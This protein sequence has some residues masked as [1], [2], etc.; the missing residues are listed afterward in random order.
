MLLIQWKSLQHSSVAWKWRAQPLISHL[1]LQ[2]PCPCERC[3]QKNSVH[4]SL[5]V[6]RT[7]TTEMHSGINACILSSLPL[8]PSTLY[9]IA[10]C[11]F[12][13]NLCFL[14]T[15]PA[16]HLT[17]YSVVHFSLLSCSLSQL[18]SC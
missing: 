14:S 7:L 6:F 16:L 8:C 4:F 15:Y 13:V 10:S 9:F 3:R 5:S 18:N 17:T 2:Y 1:I 11:P 12:A